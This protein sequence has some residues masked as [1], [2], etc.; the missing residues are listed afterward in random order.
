MREIFM[1]IISDFMHMLYYLVGVKKE[2]LLSLVVTVALILAILNIVGTC[3]IWII[4]FFYL[5]IIN[6]DL[7]KDL[8]MEK[9]N[10]GLLHL[11]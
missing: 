4:V 8:S 6:G 1:W 2:S 5:W 7:T 9:R 11:P 10:S 3:V